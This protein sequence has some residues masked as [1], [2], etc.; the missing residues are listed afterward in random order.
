M[1]VHFPE[2]PWTNAVLPWGA[3]SGKS[4][5]SAAEITWEALLPRTRTWAVAP[6][7]V[8]TD[9]VF[10]YAYHWIVQERVLDDPLLLGKGSVTYASRPKN[11]GGRIELKNG[12]WIEGKSA[13]SPN[14][15]AGEQL[16]LIVFD[17]CARCD[18]RIWTEYLEPRTLDRKGRAMFISTPRGYNW[19]RKYY[20]RGQDPEMRKLGWFSLS[21]KTA[22]NPFISE[23][24]IEKKR[25]TTPEAIFRQEYEGDFTT[26]AGLVFPDFRD[27]AYPDGHLFDPKDIEFDEYYSYYRGV[28]IGSRLPTACLWGAVDKNNDIYIYREYERVGPIHEE[29]AQ[30][31]AA[32]T[33]EK[34]SITYISPDARRKSGIRTSKEEMLCPMDIYRRAGIYALPAA[35]NVSAGIAEVNSYLRATLEDHPSHP[36]LY[37]SK[38]CPR[39]RETLLSYVYPDPS[40][41]ADPIDPPDKPKKYNDHLPDALRYLLASTPRHQPYWI[42]DQPHE[43]FQE[44]PRLKGMPSVP[45]Y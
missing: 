40:P 20:F 31:I 15:L 11:G 19:F 45:I 6:T 33:G 37:I 26:Q 13:E 18:E 30:A 4:I 12:S 34:V 1:S 44:K 10:D 21:M 27:S 8:L 25:A 32:L 5:S 39:L 17:E 36:K 2:V 41:R 3:R 14:S 38:E 28:D 22:E 9:K 7:Y 29:H 24:E 42:E 23:E 43:T 16:D 35:D